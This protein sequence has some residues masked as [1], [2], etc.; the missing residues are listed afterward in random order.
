MSD[1]SCQNV[2]SDQVSCKKRKISEVNENN[3]NDN[4]LKLKDFIPE[5][6]LN[7]NTNRKTVC[8]QGKFN[9]KIGVGLIIL[10]KNAFKEEELNRNGYFSEDSELR[11]LFQNDIYGNFECFPRSSINGKCEFTPTLN[12]FTF[13]NPQGF[14]YTISHQDTSGIISLFWL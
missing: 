2:D 1:G 11:T 14:Y 9:D 4:Q 12:H 3:V 13:N 5:K 10:E 6:V 7:N 8:V